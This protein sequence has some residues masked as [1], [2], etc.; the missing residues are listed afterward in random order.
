M[1]INTIK[2]MNRV[3]LIADN[4][5]VTRI[6]LISI[7]KE[8]DSKAKIIEIENYN[9]LL[10]MLRQYTDSVVV[11]DYTLFDFFSLDHLLNIKS[12]AKKTAWLLFFDEVEVNFIRQLLHL[13]ST[14]SI[15]LKH[16]SKSVIMD[17]FI[18]VTKGE[19]FWC[20]YAESIMKIDVPLLKNPDTLTVSEKSI[21][22]EIALGKTTKEIAVVKNLSF[23]TIN[24]H[25]RNIYR[26]LGVNS[27]NEVTR[28][29]LQAGLIDL[30]EYYI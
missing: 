22:R 8:F 6:G 15:V 26:K 18:C 5:D 30:I 13:D 7:I 25:R 27:V 9:K 3:Y 23:H 12:G 28:Y 16:S 14:I 10:F 17:A 29:A 20:D 4:Q 11:V 19:V 1:L 21:L 24:A 2:I